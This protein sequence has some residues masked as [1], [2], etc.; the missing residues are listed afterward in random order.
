MQDTRTI[1][2][3]DRQTDRQVVR[4]EVSGRLSSK[5]R[6]GMERRV[7]SLLFAN[8]R[9]SSTL[10]MQAEC[11]SET[12]AS[13][14]TLRHT[15][16]HNN[17]VSCLVFTVSLISSV[18]KRVL[19]VS[20]NYSVSL[21]YQASRR[22]PVMVCANQTTNEGPKTKVVSLL[23]RSDTVAA[24]AFDCWSPRIRSY[25]PVRSLTRVH[26][27]LFCLCAKSISEEFFTVWIHW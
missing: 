8:F 9:T 20:A 12:L 16:A 3:T 1:L 19:T 22:H 24:R 18:R 6:F 23:T 10:K 26:P 4:S 15:T 14:T 13:H 2:Q 11:S 17:N 25:L 7:V 5:L 27:Q 21:S